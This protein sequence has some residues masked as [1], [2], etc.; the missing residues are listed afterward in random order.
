MQAIGVNITKL[1]WHKFIHFVESYT[2]SKYRKIMVTLM[3][4]SSLQ[5]SMSKFTPIFY[6]IDPLFSLRYGENRIEVVCFRE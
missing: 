4:W 2:I 6:E 5:K 1:F 3:Q